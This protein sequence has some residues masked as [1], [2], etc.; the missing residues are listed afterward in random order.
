MKLQAVMKSTNAGFSHLRNQTVRR[1]LCLTEY[2]AFAHEI[3]SSEGGDYKPDCLLGCV[4]L[5]PAF[6]LVSC[7]A[8]SLTKKM[9]AICS[10]ETS[11]D[12]QRATLCYIPEQ[13]TLQNHHWKP[14]IL[15]TQ[16]HIPKDR[17]LQHIHFTYMETLPHVSVKCRETCYEGIWSHGGEVSSE[18]GQLSPLPICFGQE[19]WLRPR[20][21]LD[22]VLY[23]NVPSNWDHS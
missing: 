9:E 8:Y 12:F 11:V 14:Q 1:Y 21:H 4:C 16:H 22:M 2:L 5:P 3:W 6:V 18:P 20:I 15:H 23:R 7:S 13:R 19:V 17:I 10:S